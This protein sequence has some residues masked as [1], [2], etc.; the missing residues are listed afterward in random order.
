MKKLSIV[1]FLSLSVLSLFAIGEAEGGSGSLRLSMGGSTTVEPII[2]SA[3]EIYM[4]EVDLQAELSYDAI[5]STAG[6]RGVLNGIYDMGAAS[7]DLLINEKEQG[8]QLTHIALDGLAIIVNDTV[9]LDDISL[10][11]LAGIFVGEI[12]NWKELGGPDKEIIV[13]NRDEAS[14]T[15]GAFEELVLEKVYGDDGRFLRNALITESNGNMATMV[16]Q[17]PYSIGYGSL[18]IIERLESHGGKALTLDGVEDNTENILNGRY[19]IIR[20]LSMITYGDPQG[21]SKVFIEFLLSIRGREIILEN[22]FVPIQ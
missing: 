12:K 10:E 21:D 22:S 16:G 15:L 2:S 20:P 14:G 9:P 13:I 8:V 5:G 6:I 18:A 17:T 11:D 4:N 7:R 1:L 3:M 19:P